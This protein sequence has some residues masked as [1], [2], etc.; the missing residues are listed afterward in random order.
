MVFPF[1]GFKPYYIQLMDMLGIT[2][3]LLLG[4]NLIFGF[5]GQISVAQAGFFGLGAYAAGLLQTRLNWPFEPAI[6]AATA[7]PVLLAVILGTPI[8][9]LKGYYLALGTIGLGTMIFEALVQWQD[10]T[11]GPIGVMDIKRPPVLDNDT[12]YYYLIWIF[13]VLGFLLVRNLV[14]SSVGR[15]WV[16]I[17]ENEL[18][19]SAMGIDPARYKLLAFVLSAAFAGLA[20]GLYAFL[21]R[22]IS[23]DSFGL[24]YSMILIACLLISGAGTLGGVI[25]ASCLNILLPEFAQAFADYNVLVFGTILGP[26][27]S[28]HAQGHLGHGSSPARGPPRQQ[29]RDPP[30]RPGARARCGGGV[31]T[32]RVENVTKSF[33]GVTA[34]SEVSTEIQPGIITSLIG[35]NG[36]GKTTLF[37]V[38]TSVYPP[39]AGRVTLDGHPISS[40]MPHKVA[41]LGVSR[42]F[43]TALLFDEMT[44]LENVLVGQHRSVSAGFFPSALGL[45]GVKARE[46][47]ARSEAMRHLDF[48]GL[49]AL[50]NLRAGSLPY[51]KKRLLE[52]ARA[53]SAGPAYLLLDEPA[54]GLN[55]EET[56]FL[57]G[58]LARIKEMGITVLLVEHDMSLVMDISDH[59]VV[60]NF[61][62]KLAEGA[63]RDIRSDRRVIEAYLGEED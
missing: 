14:G 25:I 22:Y 23:P 63:P 12:I 47:H 30:P 38:I 27:A 57:G 59:V 2:L 7:C 8:L 3:L 61:G 43:Q 10:L 49:G 41:A 18:A 40:M 54:A 55:N 5:A 4:L 17:R 9:K 35:P 31:M 1:L 20:G 36:A 53:L 51:G 62:K 19:A 29:G 37:N 26:G 11:G 46:R 16:A 15:A 33:G 28:L 52:L 24:S 39:T 50:A 32:I 21:N 6:L 34:L 44:V 42:T 48:V 56:A 13:A 45:P 60:L 58:L